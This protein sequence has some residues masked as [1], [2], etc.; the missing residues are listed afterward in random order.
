MIFDVDVKGGL[1]LKHYFGEQAL[2][3]FVKVPSLE[4]LESRLQDRGT[5]TEET[6]SR[7][8]YKAKFEM[9]FEPQFD[10]TVLNDE[11]A[12]SSAETIALVTEFLKH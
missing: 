12:R 1:A 8:V 5:E 10:V 6:L 7:R 11:F 2:A 9:T 4:V 3:I